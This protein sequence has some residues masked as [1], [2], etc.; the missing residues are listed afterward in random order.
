MAPGHG[1]STDLVYP[2]ACFQLKN[3]MRIIIVGAGRTGTQLARYLVQEK[4]DVSLI[5]S[6]EERARHA[7]NRL[8]CLVLHDE[9]NSLS[10]LEEA[11]ISK[12]DALVC[13]TESDE[14]NMII[15][16]LAASRH[17]GL[18][19]I[20]RVRNNDYVRLNQYAL[21]GQKILGID[22]FIHPDVE[23]ARAVLRA[24]SHGAMGNILDFTGTPYELGSIMVAEGSTFD[25]LCIKDYYSHVKEDSLITMVERESG[26]AAGNSAD[27]SLECILPVGST[28]LRKGDRIHILAKEVQMEHI[29]S[30]AGYQERPF[31][32]IGIVGGGH[33]GILVA[34]GI[35]EK[36]K[37]KKPTFS[38]LF[39]S[40]MPKS[41]RQLIIVE[42]NYEVCKELASRFPEALVL[43][44]DISDERFVAEERLGDLDL[45]IVA[46]ANQE[47][48]IVT[49]LYLKSRGV[50]RA[51]ATV[52]GGGYETIARQLGVDVVIPMQSV[53]VD[54]IFS[55]LMGKG[56]RGLHHLGDGTLEILEVDITEG[57][58]VVD[59]PITG[60][61]LS[62][63]GLIMLVNREGDSFIPHGDYTFKPG[64]KVILIANKGNEAELERF[65]GVKEPAAQPAATPA[66]TPAGEP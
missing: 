57:S 5:E 12:A 4:H 36:N 7:S 23:A 49:A 27:S 3:P 64:D 51:I 33:L 48:N 15:C 17:S 50:N 24:V 52:S 63:G 59:K 44:E 2:E 45:I 58:S 6:N 66:A 13:V 30:L 29:F 14:I 34:E 8:D 41:T 60:F 19:K 40:F 54:S 47:L 9:G 31:K 56:I 21:D 28:V 25:G 26:M 61:S 38:S 43:N 37:A 55:N 32:R 42:Q 11:G 22:Y 10:T 35:L 53:V 20:A 62:K 39:H 46:T 18:L 65:F 16:G 1:N